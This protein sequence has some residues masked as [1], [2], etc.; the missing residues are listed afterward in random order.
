MRATPPSARMSAGMRS[1]A[2]TAQAPASSAMRACS[3]VVTSMMTPPFSIWASPVLTRTVPVRP[4]PSATRSPSR[5]DPSGKVYRTTSERPPGG[6]RLRAPSP[7]VGERAYGAAQT[8]VAKME[9]GT[10]MASAVTDQ[11]S[12]SAV[13]PVASA[14]ADDPTLNPPEIAR[15]PAGHV[16]VAV[17]PV[18]N[19]GT[20]TVAPVTIVT[21]A[22]LTPPRVPGAILAAVTAELAILADVT[23]ELAILADVTAELASLADVTD[24]WRAWPTGRRRWRSWPT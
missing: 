21:L 11:P 24:R 8:T 3:G 9:A 4:L 13:G 18:E 17:V 12:P 20:V 7:V 1:R 23:A 22:A 6:P 14:K 15:C 19:A 10:S 2:I 5:S 16:A